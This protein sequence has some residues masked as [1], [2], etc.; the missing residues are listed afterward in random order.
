ME[1]DT[2]APQEPLVNRILWLLFIISCNQK[3]PSKTVFY[4][5]ER[6]DLSKRFVTY[7]SKV[8]SGRIVKHHPGVRKVF[9]ESFYLNGLKHGSWKKFY[10]NGALFEQRKYAKSKK[11]GTYTGYYSDGS[12]AFKYNFK[13]G[14]YHGKNREWTK[15]GRLIR[16]SNY[17]KGRES[18]SQK[19]WYIDGRIKSNYV[20][21]NNRRYG[22]LGT[23]NC[24]NVSKSIF[25]I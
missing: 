24:I 25:A 3:A 23:K 12:K 21:R 9:S 22:L 7:D 4:P 8:F 18:G 11:V 16:E 2:M 1:A 17:E 10:L 20:I 14:E 5:D 19:I 6:L 13:G 15:E